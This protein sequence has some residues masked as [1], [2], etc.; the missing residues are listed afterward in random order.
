MRKLPVS[1]R[2]VRRRCSVPGRWAALLT[3]QKVLLQ[4]AV[5]G[6]GAQSSG[7]EPPGSDL[8]GQAAVRPR[9]EHGLGEVLVPA[10]SIQGEGLRVNHAIS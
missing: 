7:P 3:P 2:R 1:P 9:E 6:G 5:T 4:E 8:A 10:V